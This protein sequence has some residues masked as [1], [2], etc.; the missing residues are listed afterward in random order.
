MSTSLLTPHSSP[1]KSDSG[2][3]LLE[4][5]VVIVIVAVLAGMVVPAINHDSGRNVADAAARMVMMINQAQQEAILTSQIWQVVFEPAEHSYEFRRRSGA[6]FEPVVVS[7]Y[8]GKFTTATVRM[9]ELEINGQPI[10]TTGEVY[11][12]PT[13]E[14][15]PFRLILKGGEYEY[16]I[17]MGPVGPVRVEGPWRM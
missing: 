9:D 1:E 15:D 5:L 4:L 16:R 11:L 7:P 17:A 12:F 2:F 8:A 13:G 14:Q 3:T 6:D 10:R